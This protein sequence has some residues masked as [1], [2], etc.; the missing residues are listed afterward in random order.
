MKQDGVWGADTVA[1]FRRESFKPVE[2]LLKKLDFDVYR[3][4]GNRP[5]KLNY[6]SKLQ[7]KILM[8]LPNIVNPKKATGLLPAGKK[9]ATPPEPGRD[10]L[11]YAAKNSGAKL[12]YI[13]PAVESRLKAIERF[14]SD[15]MQRAGIVS[16][17]SVAERARK[18]FTRG[19]VGA[20]ILTPTRERATEIGNQVLKVVHNHHDFEVRMVVGG[21]ARKVQMRDF[22]KGRRDIVVGTPGRIRDLL[23]NEDEFARGMAKASLLIIDDAATALQ[24]GL[25]DDL[26]AIAAYLPPKEKRQTWIH[27]HVLSLPL[28]Q[29]AK[30]M[31]EEDYRFFKE[32]IIEKQELWEKVEQYHTV[33]PSAR[34]Q[35][36]HLCRLIA[37]DQLT[38]PGKSKVIIFT[39]AARMAQLFGTFLRGLSASLPGGEDTNVYELHSALAPHEREEITQSWRDDHSGCSVLVSSEISLSAEQYGDCSRIIQVG[40]PS[41]SGIFKNRLARLQAPNVHHRADIVL[42]S[43]EIGFLTWMLGEHPLKPCTTG[44]L[45]ELVEKKAEA[46]DANPAAFFPESA[47]EQ[48]EQGLVP[49]EF[50]KFEGSVAERVKNTKTV[51]EELLPKMDELAIKETFAALLGFYIPKSGDLRAA[52]PIIVQG[53]KEWAKECCGLEEEPYVSPE[54]LRR[55]G[56][57][58]GRT[59]HFGAAWLERVRGVAVKPWMLKDV[60]KHSVKTPWLGRGLQKLKDRPTEEP[61]WAG[62]AGELDANDPVSDPESYRS[63]TYGRASEKLNDSDSEEIRKSQQLAAIKAARKEM[64]LPIAELRTNVI[65]SQPEEPLYLPRE[66]PLAVE[67]ESAQG[68]SSFQAPPGVGRATPH[69]QSDRS[70]RQS[71][72]SD[73]EIFAAPPTMDGARARL[74]IRLALNSPVG[75]RR[76]TSS[77]DVP[78]GSDLW[79]RPPLPVG[80]AIPRFRRNGGGNG[81]GSGRGGGW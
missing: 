17:P 15:A 13:L 18:V 2:V 6:L 67:W 70:D 50:R 38:N 57:E 9:G 19:H 4:L 34:D 21:Q 72:R 29:M 40:I 16:D 24:L 78:G 28:Q 47:K 11:I 20:V 33:L 23:E 53:C 61:S 62:G 26:D 1:K 41:S 59:R 42:C 75:P 56:M 45:Q 49:G 30:S 48:A 12:A 14:V 32:G 73:G 10:V 35:L 79:D 5:W 37:H 54:F 3:A 36:P 71:D 8:R 46:F 51:Y 22:M 39:P 69:P 60:A 43:W 76:K 31:L 65:N 7:A 52:R 64:G 55:L 74:K 44:K 63:Q 68:P 77:D 66:R 80:N 81:N 58:D 25:R 27:T